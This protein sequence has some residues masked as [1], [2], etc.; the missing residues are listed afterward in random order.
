MSGSHV[1]KISL[2]LVLFVVL[3]AFAKLVAGASV[4]WQTWSEAPFA[5]AKAENKL[6]LVDLSAEWCGFCKKM[7]ATTW[8]DPKVLAAIEKDYVPVKIVDEKDPELAARYR[9]Y[10]RPAIIIMDADG[11]ELMHKRGYMKP[12]WMEWLLQAVIQEQVSEES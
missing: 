3:V 6:V 10:G 1:L 4:P 7:D 12:Q 11:T 5:Q 2:F 9:D 8:R